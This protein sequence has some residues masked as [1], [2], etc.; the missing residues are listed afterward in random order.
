MFELVLTKAP[1]IEVD[2]KHHR[3]VYANDGSLPN[4]LESTYA[5]LAGCAGVYARKA[6]RE[7]GIDETGIA[8]A[9][10]VVA[11]AGRP[12]LPERFVT[13]VDFP[14]RFDAA[15]R[16]AVLASIERCAVKALMTHGAG[17]EFVVAETATA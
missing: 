12:L 9:M 3:Y 16:A 15:Q 10:K 7:L 8:I 6:C 14:E 1:R 13:T 2:S 5:A 4:P 17:M 11:S